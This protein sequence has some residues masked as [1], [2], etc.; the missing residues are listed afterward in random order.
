MKK[1]IKITPLEI[2]LIIIEV[3]FLLALV[4]S[5]RVYFKGNI[6]NIV[7]SIVLVL[8]STYLTIV[9][10]K[11]LFMPYFL[12]NSN[13]LL[14]GFLS[15]GFNNNNGYEPSIFKF[16]MIA[17]GVTAILLGVNSKLYEKVILNE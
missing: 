1:K 9:N 6:Q 5:T 11:K 2:T 10:R 3:I 16:R 17:L 14:A 7:A 13:A 4:A 8:I 12:T 15:G